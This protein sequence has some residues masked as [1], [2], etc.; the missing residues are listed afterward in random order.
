M[1]FSLRS[2]LAGLLWFALILA[3]CVEYQHA[4]TRY[5]EAL[6][7]RRAGFFPN[8]QPRKSSATS[9]GAAASSQ[10]KAAGARDPEAGSQSQRDGA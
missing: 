1:Q 9:R 3:V 4:A 2:L 8:P 5:R 7:L 10:A 6:E